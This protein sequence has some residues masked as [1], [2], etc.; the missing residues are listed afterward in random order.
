MTPSELL[1]YYQKRKNDFETLLFQSKGKINVI[2]NLR[3]L[4]AVVFL[5]VFYF[6]VY[7]TSIFYAEIPLLILFIVL[8]K[9][10]TVLFENKTHLENLVKINEMELQ[11]V[12]GNDDGFSSGVEFINPT[13]PYSHDLDIF[14][15][16]SLYQSINR[17][18]TIQ[19]RKEMAQRLTSPLLT[20]EEIRTNQQAAQ[21]LATRTD[22]RQHFQSTRRGG[23]SQH[24]RLG[25]GFD[26]HD[27]HCRHS[28]RLE[29]Q[30]GCSNDWD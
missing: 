19:G 13:H 12:K 5:T 20:A 8:V 29:S 22:F 15:E 28:Q 21:E 17:C 27:W 16:G 1:S 26:E 14:G 24:F 10:H 2:S 7:N 6:A 30:F 9:W 25:I 23:A 18:N 3:I 11:A 4:V